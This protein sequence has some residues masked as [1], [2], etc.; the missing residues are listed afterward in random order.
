MMC[1]RFSKQC[2]EPNCQQPKAIEYLPLSFSALTYHGLGRVSLHLENF[3]TINILVAKNSWPIPIL[4]IGSLAIKLKGERAYTSLT[5]NK[6]EKNLQSS[7][8]LN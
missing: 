3:V 5:I 7:A 4:F 6:K 8:A 1:I 2:L